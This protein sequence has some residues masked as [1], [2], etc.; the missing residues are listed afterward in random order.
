M[1]EPRWAGITWTRPLP[2]E[3]P[4][5]A[6]LDGRRLASGRMRLF[7]GPRS[8][9]GARYFALAPEGGPGQRPDGPAVLALYHA[10]PLPS[11]NWL[12]VLLLDPGLTPAV[13]RRLFRML[14]R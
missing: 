4:L 12:E 14:A 7:L 2:G 3:E 9:F 1:T 6:R 13:R 5:L 8:R 10:G 11:Y